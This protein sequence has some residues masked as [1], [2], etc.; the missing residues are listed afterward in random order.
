MNFAEYE[1]KRNNISKGI[2]TSKNIVNRE[3][4]PIENAEVDLKGFTKKPKDNSDK[5]KTSK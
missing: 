1:Q 3:Y 4:G 5:I 2:T